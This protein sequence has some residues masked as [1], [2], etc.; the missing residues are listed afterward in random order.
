MLGR[1]IG[2]RNEQGV[3]YI[4]AHVTTFLVVTSLG[5]HHV[6][7]TADHGLDK[8]WLAW[9]QATRPKVITGRV[10]TQPFFCL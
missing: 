2:V 7:G 3:R 1:V 5:M 6:V 4:N 10:N 9:I 8:A